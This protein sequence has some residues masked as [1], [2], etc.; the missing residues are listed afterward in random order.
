MKN[1]KNLS[2]I[3]GE[4]AWSM[5]RDHLA[6]LDERA[7]A[8]AGLIKAG[9]SPA[10]A[11]D[12]A[13]NGGSTVETKIAGPTATIEIVGDLCARAPWYAKAYMGVLDPFD[14]ADAL[15]ALA[16]NAAITDVIVEMD[17]CGGTVSGAHECAAAVARLR[18]AGK[19]VTVRV[20]GVMASAAYWPFAGADRIVATATSLIGNIGVCRMLIDTTAAQAEEGISA[21]M[22]ATAPAKAAMAGNAGKVDALVR[23]EHQRLVD[24][25][26][27]VF[28]AAVAAGRKLSGQ[29][30]DAV[31]TGQIWLATEALALGLIDAIDSPADEADQPAGSTPA[32]PPIA[33]SL[34]GDGVDHAHLTPPAAAGLAQESS[35]DAKFL[36][37][38]TALSVAHPTHAEAFAAEAAKPGASIATLE[39]FA[40]PIKAKA[41][42]DAH[43]AALA[44]ANAKAAAAEARAVKAEADKAK[45]EAD[46]AAAR[47]HSTPHGD[48]GGDQESKGPKPKFTKEQMAGGEIPK[49]VF[50]S[51]H[52]EIIEDAA[53]KP[54]A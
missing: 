46:L 8:V 43:A 44:D 23:A 36:A 50:A 20:A 35:M 9:M 37:A 1:L 41:K 48:P 34:D 32:P 25:L 3:F 26:G 31:T 16:S 21:E 22:L 6:A 18:A 47:N 17:S 14:V 33:P 49:D 2:A 52:Y 19:R 13:Y 38:L 4:Q 12:A 40:A 24:G 42:E 51:G 15:D 10:N 27:S 39:A 29:A 11:V 54:A 45:A 7:A 28:F 53:P 5:H 30:L